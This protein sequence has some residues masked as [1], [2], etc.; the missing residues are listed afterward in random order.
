MANFGCILIIVTLSA[1]FSADFLFS[2][3]VAVGGLV[4]VPGAAVRRRC[5]CSFVFVLS[6]ESGC[7]S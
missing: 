5:R 7:G 1:A 6:S 3:F 4:G 2:W